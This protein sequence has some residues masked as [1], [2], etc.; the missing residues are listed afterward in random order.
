MHKYFKNCKRILKIHGVNRIKFKDFSLRFEQII[1]PIIYIRTI[2][3]NYHNISL[4]TLCSLLLVD[5]GN[6][7]LNS[8]FNLLD[9]VLLTMFF[10]S[11]STVLPP[12]T[13]CPISQSPSTHSPVQELT[14][15]YF[16]QIT[17]QRFNP[18]DYCG[19]I[20]SRKTGP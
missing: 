1:I 7:E 10:L 14:S 5:L 11:F 12:F 2:F 18:L 17:K 9:L 3:I 4:V 20:L 16:T 13:D 6:F 8:L 15:Q 19:I